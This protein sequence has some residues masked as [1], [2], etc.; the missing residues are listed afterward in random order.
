MQIE[1]DASTSSAS[2]E[3]NGVCV[4]VPDPMVYGQTMVVDSMHARKQ[5]MAQRVMEGGGGSGF[6]ALP[7]GFGTLEELME[8]TTWN[9]LGIHDKPVV[10]FNVEGYWDGLLSWVNGGVKAGFIGV[11]QKDILVEAKSAEEVGEK[12]RGYVAVE[13]R[14]HLDWSAK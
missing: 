12:L 8:I 2:V 11:G 7:G 3:Y 1:Q 13:Q 4:K 9:K 10:V 14:M 5:A 6:V